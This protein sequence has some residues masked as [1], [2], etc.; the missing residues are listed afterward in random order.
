[1][2]ARPPLSARGE[3][4][5][6]SFP[7]GNAER[8]PD[9]EGRS[10]RID[11]EAEPPLGILWSPRRGPPIQGILP[12]V[13]LVLLLLLAPAL[14][15]LAPIPSAYSGPNAAPGGSAS[16]PR[17]AVA[18]FSLSPTNGT[19][20]STISGTGSGF[21]A[22][23]GITFAVGGRGIASPCS[24]DASGKFPGT[25]GSACTFSVP[26]GPGGTTPVI[27]TTGWKVNAT[28]GVG[29]FPSTLGYDPQ[30]NKL[31][32][33][34]YNSGNLSILNATTN[35]VI[36]NVAV[37]TN[38]L[39]I[40]VDTAKG[41][42]YVANA[43]SNNVS[44]INDTTDLVTTTIS[45]GNRPT[46]AMYDP[47]LGEIFV[48]NTNGDDVSVIS[49]ATNAV[50]ATIPVGSHPGGI[51]FDPALDEMFVVNAFGDSVSVISDSSNSI[52]ATVGVGNNPYD[53]VYDSGMQEVFVPNHA[54]NTM[55]VISA[56][57]NTVV[58]TIGIGS[59]PV[60]TTYDSD[61]GQVLVTNYG[62][63]NVSAIADASNVVVSNVATPSG[64]ADLLYVPQQHAVFVPDQGANVVSR[65]STTY[66]ITTFTVIGSLTVLP[67]RAEVGQTVALSGTGFG[68]S[69]QVSTLT[70]GSSPLAC[71]RASI[72][73]CVG[74][75]LTTDSAGAFV[76]YVAVPAVATAGPYPLN[77]SDGSGN[78]ATALVT[79]FLDPTA[80]VPTASPSTVGVG[81]FVTFTVAAANGAGGYSYVWSGLPLG[82]STA[83]Q[84]SFTCAPQ[85]R[86]T[87]SISVT[88]TD[89]NGF[90][91]T[92]PVLQFVV[93]PV[94]TVTFSETGL[95]HGTGWGVVVG[96]LSQTSTTGNATIREGNGTYS[97]VILDPTGY[98]TNN[99]G[100]FTVNGQNKIILVTFR[101]ETYPVDFIVIGLPAGSNWSV[102]ISNA[103]T[104][105]NE[106]KSTLGNAILVF[107]PN[108]TY[109]I[110]FQLPSGY[111]G[112]FSST[113]ITVAGKATSATLGATHQPSTLASSFWGSPYF[114][115]AAIGIVA[116]IGAGIAIAVRRRPPGG[117]YPTTA[118]QG[119]AGGPDGE[120]PEGPSP[121]GATQAES[122]VPAEPSREKLVREADPLAEVF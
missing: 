76:A 91:G 22:S 1:M 34:N 47:T 108:G 72:G 92:S 95:P 117:G 10:R 93:Y 74:G 83:N 52:V 120:A 69:A 119:T 75:V 33:A 37:G 31:F 57:S 73:S 43:G 29:A 4:V 16:L 55:S 104:G 94:Y 103:T 111:S 40:A 102:T 36:G 77:A 32:V 112:N 45:A 70:L 54:A 12:S 51:A 115:L 89:S 17:P 38:P 42:V 67:T 65:L 15:V 110:T 81:D 114:Y 27:A 84:V 122:D 97:Y 68:S 62:T 78:H 58:A 61:L 35:K 20:G 87:Y 19:A 113:Q 85:A 98:V 96:S 90:S 21:P 88:V 3:G 13:A 79:V 50:V 26:S 71:I 118:S 107:L 8:T 101:K 30:H 49:D 14:L 2:Q 46:G 106:T 25:T 24:T 116:A 23:T 63:N 60:H 5:N 109:T 66:A 44:V 121:P 99:T 82:C 6:N 86:G 7:T 56:V 59:S 80:S 53:P 100:S 9:L 11:P 48:V 41:S 105:F 18:S 28:I 39:W 64:P